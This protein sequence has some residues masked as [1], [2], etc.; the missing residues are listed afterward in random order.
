MSGTVKPGQFLAI[1]G[2]SGTLYYLYI[3]GAGKTTL[4]NY[5]AGKNPSKNISKEGE[6]L[7][8]GMNRSNIDYEKYIG[9]VQQ[10]DILFQT[11]TVREWLEFAARMKLK[12]GTDYN[13]VVDNIIESLKLERAANTKIGGPLVKG[14]LSCTPPQP[15]CRGEGGT[16][17]KNFPVLPLPPPK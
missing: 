8:N 4:L 12:S 7:V 13:A 14:V 2:A 3:L 16:G 17:S 9:Y 5:L 15:P 1:I 11:L 10:D 6:V